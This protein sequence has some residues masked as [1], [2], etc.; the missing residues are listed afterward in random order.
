MEFLMNRSLKYVMDNKQDLFD[1]FLNFLSKFL[2]DQSEFISRLRNEPETDMVI[3][4]EI[5]IHFALESYK[6]DKMNN[7]TKLITY[8]LDLK[9]ISKILKLLK[10]IMKEIEIKN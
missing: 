7:I 2:P 8:L 10:I 3:F 4:K 1:P 6:E 9:E 5:F